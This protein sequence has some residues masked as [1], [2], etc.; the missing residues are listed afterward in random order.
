MTELEAAWRKPKNLKD[1]FGSMQSIPPFSQRNPQLEEL[2]AELDQLK[3]TLVEKDAENLRLHGALAATKSNLRQLNDSLTKKDA[4]SAEY[5]YHLDR[6]NR[7]PWWRL[8]KL[9][10]N[11]VLLPQLFAAAARILAHRRRPTTSSGAPAANGPEGPLEQLP[12]PCATAQTANRWYNLI[13]PRVSIIVVNWN[14][15]AMTLRCLE[16]IWC[17]TAGIEY[18]IILVDNGSRPDELSQIQ[19]LPGPARTIKL[20]R[21]RYF[22]EANNIGVEAAMGEYVCLLN[23]DAFVHEDWLRP[24]VTLLEQTPKAGAVGPRFIYFDG[25]LQEAGA[26]VNSDGSVIQIGQFGDPDDLIF[27]ANR[28]VDYISAAC[29]L[30]RRRSFLKVLGF[31]PAWEPAYYE[32]VELCLKLRMSGLRTFYCSGATVTHLGNATCCDPANRVWIDYVAQINKLKFRNRW[33]AFLAG[34]EAAPALIPN[35]NTDS[36]PALPDRPSIALFTSSNLTT[37][38]DEEYLLA[39]A[40]ALCDFAVVHLVT[41]DVVSRLR[42]LSIGREL[43]CNLNHVLPRTLA[44]L[45]AAEKFDIAFV[46]GNDMLPQASNLAHNIIFVCRSAPLPSEYERKDEGQSQGTVSELVYCV[47]DFVRPGVEKPS[48]TPTLDPKR[49]HMLPPPI[50]LRSPNGRKERSILHVGRFLAGKHSE[51][52]NFL[53]EAFRQLS[54]HTEEPIALHLAGPTLP[55]QEHCAYYAALVAAATDLNV[56]LHPNPLRDE[57][58]SLFEQCSIYWDAAGYPGGITYLRSSVVE[59]MSAGCIPIVYFATEPS[60]TIISETVGFHFSTLD[61][62]CEITERHVLDTN[63]NASQ[64][65]RKA[66]SEVALLYGRNNFKK[67]IK[68]MVE[69]IL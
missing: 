68:E 31:D 26:I 2:E 41:P 13:S 6:I 54:V 16:Y 35:A 51:G 24:L 3:R 45:A 5:L 59:A 7:S 11:L 50:A 28:Q 57:L 61:Q 29:I 12:R 58:D 63:G 69:E 10:E 56:H 32:D 8:G 17:N 23:N 25:R 30:M 9:L 39:I 64:L 20:S 47:M 66:A 15:A 40:D 42:I 34:A 44:E 1:T 14:R 53:I 43:G 62:L 48:V 33:G 49:I 65:M 18:E 37:G 21:N 36:F 38:G 27:A 52:Q 67:S 46:L 4:Q 60:D 22:G 55:E 19:E